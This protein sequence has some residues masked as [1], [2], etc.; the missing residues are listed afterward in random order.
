MSDLGAAVRAAVAELPAVPLVVA[1]SGGPDS[2]VTAWAC[3]EVR[4][5]ANVR[6]VHIDHGWPDSPRLAAAAADIAGQLG[7]RLESITVQP[8]AGSSPE[9]QARQVRLEALA[10][11][12]GA[13]VVVTGH[14]GDDLAETVI[15]NLLRGA[16]ATGLSG[17][18]HRRGRF[19]RPLLGFRR[20]EL[21]DLADELG[22]RYV[23]DP[24]NTD[25]RFRRSIIRNEIL[26]EL[27]R[28]IDGSVVA[29]LIRTGRHL[30]G[31]D[32]LLMG[33]ASEVPITVDEGAILVPTAA[34]GT[35]PPALASRVARRALR[36]AHE[37]YPGTSR[38]VD[39]ILAVAAGESP[40]QDLAAGLIVEREGPFAAIYRP[41]P[42]AI[43]PPRRLLIPG[44]TDFGAHRVLADPVAG[45]R[46]PLGRWRA[47]LC[48]GGGSVTVRAA[49]ERDRIAIATGSK[50]VGVVL[51]EAGVPRRKRP[52]W[53]V[54]EV[55]GKIG[56]VIGARVAAWA[57]PDSCVGKWVLFERKTA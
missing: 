48:L 44:A 51:A 53:P 8:A 35:L 31:D 12:V 19:V 34:L 32:E 7:A 29:A 37:P 46:T 30:A 13:G 10:T 54:L 57:R 5:P 50:S 20:A 24:A 38:E 40:R 22:L 2:A 6:L 11:T 52:A 9:G 3:V 1:L 23:D 49:T 39:A 42:P 28:H 27:E 33:E 45:R 4:G 41:E 15:G 26:P 55:D 21:R 17:I 47:V 56:W 25:P 18:V 36:R 16:G 14:H 43:P